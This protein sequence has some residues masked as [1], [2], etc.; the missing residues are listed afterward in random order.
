MK[1]QRMHLA[2]ALFA[3]FAV[4]VLLSAPKAFAQQLAT[5]TGTV[6]DVTGAAIPG[7]QISI[8]NPSTGVAYS[9]V[10]NGAGV[11]TL[12]DIKPGPGYVL[13]FAHSGFKTV[14]V[15]GVYMNVAATRTQN[16]TMPVGAEAQTITVSA[17]DEN[18]SLDTTNATLGNN[19]QV[20]FLQQLPVENRD[21]PSAL[22]F[23][24]PGT[25]SGGTVPSDN[26][27]TVQEGAITGA[28]PD[29]SRVTLDGLDVNDMATGQFG[30]IVANAPVDS[31]QEFRG[32]VAGDQSGAIAGGGGHFQL[33]TKGG[34][35]HFHGDLNEYHRDKALAANDWFSN[36]ATPRV[37]RSPLIRN[38]FGG[39]LGGPILKNRLFFYFD[40]NGRRDTLAGQQTRVVPRDSFRN[41]ILMYYNNTGAQEALS[42]TD[43]AN[44]DPQ[45]IGFNPAL[46][47]L[48]STRYPHANDFADGDGINTAGFRFNA[49]TKYSE[50]DYVGR[51]DWNINS[52]MKLFAVTHITRTT[53]VESAIQ[54]PGDPET[55]PFLDDS[56]SW[57]VGHT[58]TFNPNMVNQAYLGETYEDYEFPNT[59]N[60]TGANQ[61]VTF[62][63]NGTGGAI[64]SSPYAS[65]INAQGRTYPIPVVRDNF[66]WV[67]GNHVVTIGGNFKWPSP[68][69]FSKLNYN[70]PTIGLS[71]AMPQL[72]PS[73]RPG[74]IGGGN[75]TS[76]YDEAF[77]LAL[78]PYTYL[79]AT[80]NYNSAL[81][82]DPQGSGLTH[83]YRYYEWSLHA[84]DTWRITPSLS[85]NYGIRWN[86]FTDPYDTNGIESVQ[87]FDFNKY[88]YDRVAQSQAGIYGNT[89]VP[90]IQYSLGGK[91]NHAP[92]YFNT[93]F[94]N[95]APNFGFAWNPKSAPNTVIN[96]SAGIV[97]DQTVI[98]AVQYQQSQ[99]SYL[100]QSV[101]NDPLGTSSTP[102]QTLKN[103]PRFTGFT[104]VPAPP[105]A[106]SVGSPYTP[107]VSGTGTNAVPTGLA[108]GQ[109]FNEIINPKLTT[110]YSIMYNFGMEQKFGRGYI[111]KISYVG[112]L[113]RRLLAQ[114]D[115]NQ[116]IDFPDKQ[117]DELMSTAFANVEKE[118]RAGADP[119]NLPAEPWFE[120]MVDNATGTSPGQ[121]A[122]NYGLPNSTSLIAAFFGTYLA[123]GDMADTTQALA[124][125][126]ILPPNVGMGSQFSENTFYTNRGFSSY[127][128]MLVTLHK[129][130]GNG[131][132]FDLNY[133]W[134]HSMDNTSYGGNQIALGGYGFICDVL[135]P[136]ECRSNSDFDLNSSLNGNFIYSLPFGRGAE[137]AS[138]APFWLNEA[139]GGW[140]VS[141]LPS[142]HTGFPYFIAA[143]AFVAGY[144][145][146]APAI[147][148]GPIGDLKMHINGGNGQPLQAYANPQKALSDYT[149]PVAFQIGS[150][151]NLRG[152]NYFN[153]DLGLGK[154]FP[155]YHNYR[156]VFRADAF[157]ALN[158][159]NFEAPTTSGG[160]DI[161]ES[162]QPFGIMPETTVN[163]A[164]VLQVS[165]RFEF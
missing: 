33:V 64:L 56:Y 94:N 70:T 39:D 138:H 105:S 93:N 6:T 114:A 11:Y 127:N 42:S 142:W 87:N 21:S 129:N 120:D 99:Y 52:K 98:N 160:G 47:K 9:A 116:L 152:P 148:T 130:L 149:G 101:E 62:G 75:A 1:F 82:P 161:T 34:T 145:N 2:V 131:L 29:Q 118:L 28:R 103:A 24:Q 16:E 45:H 141:G 30:S 5:V 153:I 100:F 19:F 31:V 78:A 50:N 125:S 58:W 12:K 55:S 133:T 57:V 67:H 143:N 95:I 85:L 72:K 150:R 37:P 154:T 76:L 18:E 110:P 135:R 102:I 68:T 147:L 35:N 151:N 163:D 23:M 92:G 97:Y 53:G 140:T 84:G 108:N 46:L 134:S 48:F 3:A 74:D 49:P 128:A 91:A 26:A 132:Q 144:A 79:Q 13:T 139:I 86:V 155:I 146:D 51:I 7:V 38:Q 54:F 115:A 88:F 107:F 122:A 59:Y 90:F 71:T 40:Y 89:V 164:R 83:H 41:G 137:F 69:E 156:I 77:A 104:N 4:S 159:P 117:S 121:I 123:R 162:N 111:L 106:P 27:T 8:K 44:L 20:Q 165:G 136:R 119:N 124:G 22:F 96:G 113:G 43:V 60:P 109:A 10:T 17:S 63:G 157:N 66:T 126:G 65:A 15:S 81:K 61:F 14:S 25:T 32:V 80:Y 158:H 112:R 36:N 73:L